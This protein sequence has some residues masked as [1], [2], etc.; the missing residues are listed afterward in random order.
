MTGLSPADET[1]KAVYDSLDALAADFR[2]GTLILYRT[3]CDSSQIGTVHGVVWAI[4]RTAGGP[5]TPGL[6]IETERRTI[7]CVYP[8]EV[9]DVQR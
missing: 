3:G 1:G 7:G 4:P 5:K 8:D 6:V 2:A 9:M